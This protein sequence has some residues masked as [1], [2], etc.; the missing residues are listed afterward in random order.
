MIR[1]YLVGKE[2]DRPLAYTYVS[3]PPYD[4]VVIGSLTLGQLLHFSQEQV[5]SALAEGKPISISLKP[6]LRSRR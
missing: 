1:A 5:L 2:P 4:A 3:E 6:T